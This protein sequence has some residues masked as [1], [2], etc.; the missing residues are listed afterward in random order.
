MFHEFCTHDGFGMFATV[1]GL[2]ESSQKF[3][4]DYISERVVEHLETVSKVSF[5]R[6][7]GVGARNIQPYVLESAPPNIISALHLISQSLCHEHVLH[8]AI[9]TTGISC[10]CNDRASAGFANG[11]LDD[12]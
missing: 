4:R 9:L 12:V 8:D 2:G 6:N 5:L 1:G 10:T 3:Y 11:V 7:P